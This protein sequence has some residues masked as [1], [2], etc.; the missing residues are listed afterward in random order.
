[1]A[2][3][4]AGLMKGRRTMTA[5][6]KAAGDALIGTRQHP[7]DR[8]MHDHADTINMMTT[9]RVGQRRGPSS[10]RRLRLAVRFDLHEGIDNHFSLAVSPEGDRFLVNPYGP[11]WAEV[12]ASDLLLVDAE[13]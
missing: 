9:G 7:G 6:A 5:G 12:T 2:C 13:G 1:M 11:H 10:R 4:K 8:I 3:L